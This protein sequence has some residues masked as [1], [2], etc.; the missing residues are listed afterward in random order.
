M[1]LTQVMLQVKA[2]E[3]V[4]KERGLISRLRLLSPSRTEPIYYLP[5]A[6][7]SLQS[8]SSSLS[9]PSSHP[10]PAC[11]I[12]S[13]S[14]QQGLSGAIKKVSK[15]TG[16]CCPL[17][18]MRLDQDQYSLPLLLN[19]RAHSTTNTITCKPQNQQRC[20]KSDSLASQL[21]YTKTGL[22]L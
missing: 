17:K 6:Y 11:Q 10:C 8:F 12:V 21:C 4:C 2:C 1:G 7:A 14:A 13:D 22:I 19:F 15:H 5:L 9:R 3:M 18:K 16:K 20:K